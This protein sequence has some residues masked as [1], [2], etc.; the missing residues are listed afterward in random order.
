VLPSAVIVTLA[1]PLVLSLFGAE[2]R[3]GATT[4]LQLMMASLFPRVIVSLYVTKCR[5]ENRTFLLAILQFVQ[6]ALLIAC[7][8]V[9]APAIGLTAVGWAALLAEVVPAIAV[10][11]GVVGWLRTDSRSARSAR[12]PDSR[13]ARAPRDEPN[14]DGG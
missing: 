12:Q 5:L 9:L 3:A 4:V 13:S 10:A 6:A 7:T 8:V 2:Y 14:A 1:A 11:A